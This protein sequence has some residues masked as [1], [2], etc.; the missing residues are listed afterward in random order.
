MN[1]SGRYAYRLGV[2]A[3]AVIGILVV[4]NGAKA[5]DPFAQLR[6]EMVAKAL[7]S[8]GITN[9]RVLQAMRATPRH[10]F[11]PNPQRRFAYIDTALSIGYKQTISPPFIVAYMTEMIDPQEKDVVLEIG[12]GSGYQAAVLS[13]LVKDVYTIEI[14]EPL[15]KRA[16]ARLKE[17]EYK[18]VHCKIG[19]GYKGWAE[20]AP[21]DKIIVTCSPESVPKPLI[22]QLKEGGTMIVP[23]GERYQQVFYLFEKKDGKLI[24]T[25]LQPTLFVPMTGRSEDERKVKPNGANPII[26]NG[27][28]ENIDQK[29]EQVEGWHYQRQST[30]E[31]KDSPEGQNYLK[32]QNTIPGRIAHIL[33]GMAIDGSELSAIRITL[34]YKAEN[35]RQG[36]EKYELPGFVIHFYDGNRKPIESRVLA[37]FRTSD[38]WQTVAFTTQLPRKVKEAIIQVGLNGGT[39]TLSLDDL[40]LKKKLR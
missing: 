40:K 12:T 1:L 35:L 9:K 24:Q 34:T 39:G 19:D 23:L 29:K 16:I 36:N 28:F 3:F 27:G 2:S 30:I 33:Q 21:F 8:E 11:V 10:E 22:A 13:P 14:V 38:D 7:V 15:G 32:L 20:H 37:R 17:L 18:N 4:S 25:K 6:E 5:Q 26:V 31:T